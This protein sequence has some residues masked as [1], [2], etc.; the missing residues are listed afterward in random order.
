MEWKLPYHSFSVTKIFEY[1]LYNKYSLHAY[2]RNVKFYRCFF[3]NLAVTF[4]NVYD[5]LE[6]SL[7]YNANQLRDVCTEYIC[8]NLRCFM[9]ARFVKSQISVRVKSP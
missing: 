6:F 3:F 5:L 9:E 8:N 7:L 1:H 4:R 2:N